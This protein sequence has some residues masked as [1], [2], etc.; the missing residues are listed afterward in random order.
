MELPEKMKITIQ[1]MLCSTKS[2]SG[3]KIRKNVQFIES[4][5]KH[6]IHCSIFQFLAPHCHDNNGISSSDWI[7]RKK[8]EDLSSPH[9]GWKKIMRRSKYRY[10]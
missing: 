1:Y 9:I 2:N 8:K 5:I 6:I 4:S 10:M 3:L 7:Q